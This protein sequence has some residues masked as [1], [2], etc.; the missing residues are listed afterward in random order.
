MIKICKILKKIYSVDDY[1]VF[2]GWCG[3]SLTI[4]YKGKEP[5]KALKTVDYQIT[6]EYQY[7]KKYGKQLLV[8]DYKKVGKIK[9]HKFDKHN[10]V[11]LS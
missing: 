10:P 8:S 3:D 9:I 1:Y 2:S 5:P 7:S 11:Y 6:G 4:V